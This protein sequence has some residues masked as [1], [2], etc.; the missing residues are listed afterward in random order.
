MPQFPLI[1]AILIGDYPRQPAR[2]ALPPGW[3]EKSVVEKEKF[4]AMLL[5]DL[6]RTSETATP[7]AARKTRRD[8]TQTR[9]DIGVETR[10]DR[11]DTR[12]DTRAETRVEK[13]AETKGNGRVG[14]RNKVP[15]R[16]N[17]IE[18]RDAFT[19][20]QRKNTLKRK[21][22]SDSEFEDEMHTVT[23]T[24][25]PIDD[26]FTG[27]VRQESDAKYI[28]L[29][30]TTFDMKYQEFIKEVNEADLT[31]SE[32][33]DLMVALREG[34]DSITM[35]V[36]Y[37]E[38]KSRYHQQSLA[39]DSAKLQKAFTL[40]ALVIHSGFKTVQ[41]TLSDLHVSPSDYQRA[42]TK[43]ATALYVN[44]C[45]KAIVPEPLQAKAFS[46]MYH[47]LQAC[48]EVMLYKSN[49]NMRFRHIFYDLMLTWI[50]RDGVKKVSIP[51]ATKNYKS[52]WNEIRKSLKV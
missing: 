42:T 7:A 10:V 38:L 25:R 13:R 17:S 6:I 18:T 1:S 35:V 40:V 46:V 19:T 32:V 15:Q 12:V 28:T 37:D 43:V 26:F 45:L 34:Q 3:N 2:S 5:V 50:E 27:T 16:E 47:K 49:V 14:I 22:V 39:A 21:N 20:P 8:T 48:G 31:V 4:I 11:V 51:I 29:L 30:E 33:P 23:N 24:P 41:E 52:G 9:A 36:D 44:E